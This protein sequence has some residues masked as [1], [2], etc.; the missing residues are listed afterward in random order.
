V[1]IELDL[2]PMLPRRSMPRLVGYERNLPVPLEEND[3]GASSS[4]FTPA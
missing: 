2:D 1:A 4:N 3:A